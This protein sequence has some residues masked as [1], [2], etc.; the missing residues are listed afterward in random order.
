MKMINLG[1]YIKSKIF[2]NR[3]YRAMILFNIASPLVIS[4]K[5]NIEVI[6]SLQLFL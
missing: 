6:L 1:Q 3:A 2:L 4:L 5:K